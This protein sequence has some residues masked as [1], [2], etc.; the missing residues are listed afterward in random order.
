MGLRILRAAQFNAKACEKKATSDLTEYAHEYINMRIFMRNGD[1]SRMPNSSEDQ[2]L[3][4]EAI[5]DLLRKGPARTQQFVVDALVSRG[6]VATQSS[7]SRDLRELGAIKTSRG[8]ELPDV[9]ELVEK[10]E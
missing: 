6:L 3:R 2:V 7:V 10:L 9:D 8:Y 4:R 1:Y 5:A